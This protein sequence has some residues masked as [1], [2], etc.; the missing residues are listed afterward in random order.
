MNK[1]ST[2]DKFVVRLPDGMRARVEQ[3]AAAQHT[4]MNTEIVRA[5]EAH[6]DGQVRQALLLD[7]LELNLRYQAFLADGNTPI[8]FGQ[9]RAENEGAPA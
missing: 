1:S 2:A 9:W 3:L 5:I 4:S 6:L 8:S 7:S